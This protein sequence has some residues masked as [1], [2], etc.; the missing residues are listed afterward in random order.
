M[1][2]EAIGAVGEVLGAMAVVVTLIF[3]I[4]QLR[5]TSLQLRLNSSQTASNTYSGR[6]REVLTNPEL[7]RVFRNGLDHYSDLSP[8]DQARFHGIM[9]GFQVSYAQNV[10]LWQEGVISDENFRGWEDD[11]IKI[12]KCPGSQQW[13]LWVRA[14]LGAE[15]AAAVE[16]LLA[17]SNQPPLNEIVPFL[18]AI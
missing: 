4:Q 7:T 6:I 11:W 14:M 16:D 17:R 9:M 8:D 12:L 5:Q 2:W 3:L 10:Q 15:A 18:R 13:W 1:N